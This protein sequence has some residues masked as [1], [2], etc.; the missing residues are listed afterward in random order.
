MKRTRA[1]SKPEVVI[2]LGKC[3]KVEERAN[4][5]RIRSP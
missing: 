4:P 3:R 5:T 1:F 2:F